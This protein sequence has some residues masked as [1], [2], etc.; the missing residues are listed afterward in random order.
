MLDLIIIGSGPAGL[1]AA[2]YAKRASLNFLVI[3]KEYEG[4]GQVAESGQVDNYLG[5][6]E[7]GGFELGEKF[8]E[9]VIKLGVEFLEEKVNKIEMT[10]SGGWIVELSSGKQLESRTVIYSGGT[11]RRRLEVKGESEFSGKGVSYC[12]ICDG[13]LYKNKV[14]AVVGGG[15]VA[16]DDALYLSGLCKKVYLIHRRDSYRAAESTIQSVTA[17]ENIEPVT[18]A[19]VSEIKGDQKVNSLILKDGRE[20]FVDGVFIAVG[21]VANSEPLRDLVE[22]DSRGYVIADETGCTNCKGLFVAGDVRTKQLRQVISAVS[23]GANAATSAIKY[24]KNN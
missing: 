12:A 16:L 19:E 5:Y 1:G 14:T 4:T 21:S 20:L 24:L 18:Y 2:V 7:I 8:R 3:E 22:L 13:A 23:D 15:D 10:A 17:K 6:Y 11:N 9:H